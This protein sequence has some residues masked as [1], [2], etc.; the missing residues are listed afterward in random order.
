MGSRRVFVCSGRVRDLSLGSLGLLAALG[1]PM[2]LVAC[3]ESACEDGIGDEADDGTDSDSQGEIA[4][5]WLLA[6]DEDEAGSDALIQ[7]SVVPGSEGEVTVLCPDLEL[8]AGLPADTNFSALAVVGEAL[9]ASAYRETWGD[10]L[11]R[12]D[13]CACTATE[14]GGYG[15]ELV[16]GLASDDGERLLGVAAEQGRFIAVDPQ[17]ASSQETT[18]LTEAWGSNGL[19]RGD[20]DAPL[21]GIN[22]LSDRLYEFRTDGTIRAFLPLAEDFVSVGLEYHRG[23]DEI[24]AC[25][26]AGHERDLLTV[27][28]EFGGVEVVA[29][30]VFTTA[31]DNLTAPAGALA[32]E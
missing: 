18:A 28:R 3:N 24:F 6:I 10:T 21:F 12:I 22:A 20:G 23:R 27:D 30:E 1:L 14:V 29:E 8:S 16:S 25:G 11:V 5:P 19:S 2:S 17:S 31:C 9:Y 26:V 32:C 13:P 7:I 4:Q 15:Y